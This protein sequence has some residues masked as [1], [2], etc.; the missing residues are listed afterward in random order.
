MSIW[1]FRDD[2]QIKSYR[3]LKLTLSIYQAFWHEFLRSSCSRI[4]S[5][6]FFVWRPNNPI[7]YCWN[8]IWYLICNLRW[9]RY[10]LLPTWKEVQV[11][12][13]K[14][15]IRKKEK[16]WHIHLCWFFTL[17]HLINWLSYDPHVIWNEVLISVSL[18]TATRIKIEAKE[19]NNA[20]K[21]TQKKLQSIELPSILIMIC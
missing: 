17:I 3:D 19:I 4:C 15:E 9:S 6:T 12:E 10:E 11:V 13:I 8:E 7:R 5:A 1:L 14:K 2:T 21:N 20:L 16:K 18:Q